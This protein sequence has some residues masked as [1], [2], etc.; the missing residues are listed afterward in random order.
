MSETTQQRTPKGKGLVAFVAHKQTIQER[1]SQGYNRA[2]IYEELKEKADFPLCYQQFCR[3]IKRYF[4]EPG[5]SLLQDQS[6]VSPPP[7][8]PSSPE[9]TMRR[10]V[11][12]PKTFHKTFVPGPRVPNR[13]DLV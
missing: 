1:L 13:D 7:K 6:I 5:F 3:Y 12:T 4:P 2:M 10:P 9:T 8:A 11:E